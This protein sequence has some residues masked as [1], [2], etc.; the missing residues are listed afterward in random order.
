MDASLLPSLSLAVADM[1]GFKWLM[2]VDVIAMMAH[3]F[4]FWLS[5]K[6]DVWK[7]HS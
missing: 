2:D 1:K 6:L 5:V 4:I 3:L 7:S